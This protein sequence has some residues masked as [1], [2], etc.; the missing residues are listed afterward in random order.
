MSVDN[1]APSTPALHHH[2]YTLLW[3]AGAP[4]ARGTGLIDQPALTIH[5]PPP[6]T[7]TGT[8]VVVNPGG[9]YR[10]LAADHEG[11]QVA[12]WLNRHGIAAF[13]LRYRVGP[14]YDTSTSLLDAQRA[15]RY[16]RHHASAFGISKSR[17]GMLGFSAGGHLAA[18]AGTCFDTSL[19][20]ANV[21]AE[22]QNPDAI[23]GENCRPDF[24]AL[25]Y[26]AIDH[27]LF[28]RALVA[29]VGMTD[30]VQDVFPALQSRVTAATP[31][32]F[33]MQ[34]HEDPAVTAHHVL[35]FYTA[36]LN[37][38][39]A[40]EMHIFGFGG[41]GL[42]LAPGDADL[43]QW[44]SL[45]LGWLKRSGFLVD[46][47]RVPVRGTVAIDGKPVDMGWVSL[48]SDDPTVPLVCA[49]VDGTQPGRFAADA[50][51]GAVPGRY[52][53]EVWRLAS[54]GPPDQRGDY[55]QEDAEHY[56]R[57]SPGDPSSIFVTLGGD[58]ADAEITL[59]IAT[60]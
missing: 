30:I 58:A 39:V 18:A 6:G 24:L 33:I 50:A 25:V 28:D 42:G 35:R 48:L 40:A 45:L 31:P 13:V 9:A 20:N 15:T 23:D 34:T 47:V 19:N 36:L 60:R 2:P 53:V 26:P 59:S 22:V 4:G 21:V 5:L 32:T 56:T 37:A 3:P 7:A 44:T 41:H 17:I 1:S 27:S 43:A 14:I 11:L 8:A 55:S 10:L 38:K 12:H 52:R 49:Y 29:S 16:V 54:K 51:H 46:A 57:L